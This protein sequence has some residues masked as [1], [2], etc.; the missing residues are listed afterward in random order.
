MKF[1]PIR[2]KSIRFI[3]LLAFTFSLLIPVAAMML[4]GHSFTSRSLS[5]QAVERSTYEVHLQAQNF[6]HSLDKAH[7]D[8]FYLAALR[9]F[10]QLRNALTHRQDPDQTTLWRDE[11]AQDF[12]VF[13][14]VNP[15]YHRLHYL[16][17]NGDEI[18]RIDSDERSVRNAPL[19]TLQSQVQTAYVQQLNQLADNQ[20]YVSKLEVVHENVNGERRSNVVI[21]YGLKLP[22][23]EGM[24]IL[25]L[26]AS[27]VMRNLPAVDYA[28]TW[29]LIDRDGHY[30][31]YPMS[32]AADEVPNLSQIDAPQTRQPYA[33]MFLVGNNGVFKTANSV[34]IYSRLYPSASTPDTFWI[35]YREIPNRVLYAGVGDFY[36]KSLF[37]IG[38]AIVTAYALALFISGQIIQPIMDLQRKA[39]EFAKGNP[40]SAMPTPLPLYELGDLTRSFHEMAQQ[41]DKQH[42][43]KRRLIEKLINAQEEERK[44][45]AYDLHDGL[46]Q[47]MVGARLYLSMLRASCAEHLPESIEG[48]DNGCDALSQAIVEG[49]RIIEGLHPT[50]LDDLG[51][52]EAIEE[53]AQKVAHLHQWTLQLH[54]EPLPEPPDKTV[55]VTIFRIVQEALNNICKHADA[56]RVRIRLHNGDGI[57]ITVEDD[58]SGFAAAETAD[59]KTGM[60][61]TTMRERANL[62][63][64][65]CTIESKSGA[66][67]RVA[68]WLPGNNILA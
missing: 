38:I 25:D 50:I 17:A 19:E 20:V 30:L 39:I 59:G 10:G 61:I 14:S 48:L 46:I 45:I 49:R 23:D 43:E 41:I 35:L 40:L 34:F 58:G 68:I 64:G 11:T 8:I 26:F 42:S 7:D 9:S 55:S 67:T 2:I 29:S 53:H 6:V 57:F 3:L 21:H 63:S 36:R 16:D 56:R 44:L 32:L 4:Y 28:G 47:Q 31:L 51:L 27:W 1:R 37:I 18:I 15:M 65:T 52:V 60:G 62:L 54:L 33:D 22:N 66:G 24:I 13:A 5:E 12:L